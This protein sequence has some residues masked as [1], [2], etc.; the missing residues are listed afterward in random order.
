[1]KLG[2]SQDKESVERKVMSLINLHGVTL[3]SGRHTALPVLHSRE[4]LAEYQAEE[5]PLP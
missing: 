1:M 4:S 2:R 5:L 3:G